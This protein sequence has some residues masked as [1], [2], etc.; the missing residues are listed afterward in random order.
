[1]R[2]F[3]GSLPRRCNSSRREDRADTSSAS[4]PIWGHPPSSSAISGRRRRTSTMPPW[5]DSSLRT[6]CRCPVCWPNPRAKDYSG[7]RISGSRISGPPATSRGR[8][9]ARSTS[10]CSGG[11]LCST[12]FPA[13]ML[14]WRDCT[15]SL[16]LT[17]GSTG[18]SRTISLIIVWGT[19]SGFPVSSA[20][21]SWRKT[22]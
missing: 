18:G 7:S 10:R 11:S 15:C 14:M 13:G 20:R 16:P 8:C 12:A 3:R 17:R 5:P 21:P 22:R 1:M 9:V 2:S 4:K 6:G 19:S